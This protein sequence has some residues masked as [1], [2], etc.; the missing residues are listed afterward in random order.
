MAVVAL[1]TTIC[2]MVVGLWKLFG[3]KSA[4]QRQRIDD[5][6]ALF[7]KGETDAD[8]SEVVAGLNRINNV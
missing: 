6:D 4:E 7:K 3:R 2:S 5:S 8:P 1:I